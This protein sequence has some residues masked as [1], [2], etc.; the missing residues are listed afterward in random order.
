MPDL[1][2]C[3]RSVVSDL[4]HPERLYKKTVSTFLMKTSDILRHL[5]QRSQTLSDMLGQGSSPWGETT[6]EV[7]H[8]IL[9]MKKWL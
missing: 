1:V 9:A 7:L 2:H 3:L 4:R 6:E 5:L 8:F